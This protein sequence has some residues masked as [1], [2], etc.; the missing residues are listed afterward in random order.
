MTPATTLRKVFFSGVLC[1]LVTSASSQERKRFEHQAGLNATN[2]IQT[3]ININGVSFPGTPYT[4][5]Y[6]FLYNLNTEGAFLQSVGAR[7]GI[8]YFKSSAKNSRPINNTVTDFSFQETDMRF[9]LEAQKS[10]SPR[11]TMFFGF[12]YVMRNFKNRSYNSFSNGGMIF[13]SETKEDG[14][15]SGF[16]PV[17]GFQFNLNKHLAL[18]TELSVY[19]KKG[20]S[21]TITT[22]NSPGSLPQIEN[23]EFGNS[24]FTLPSFIYFNV[25]F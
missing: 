1:L 7:A 18:G 17:L 9:G 21:N 3:L 5:Q 2:F 15:E 24:Q 13:I 16:G 4:V 12:D 10:L 22:S 25:R 23:A 14:S 6:K 20:K 11:W 19:S 8:G